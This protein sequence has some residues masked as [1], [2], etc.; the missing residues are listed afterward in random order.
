MEIMETEAEILVVD[1]EPAVALAITTA[2][3]F[4][5]YAVV[6][7]SSGEE[8]LEHVRA[9]PGRFPI[10]LSDH[11]MP[12][13]GG[14][15]LVRALHEIG[16]GGRILILSAFLSC[17]LETQYKALGVDQILAK[18]FDLRGLRLALDRLLHPAECAS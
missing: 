2:L 18:P 4:C 6:A 9:E 13:L 7:V 14:V 5:G 16:Y 1:D 8:A 12:G 11:N 17:D 3:K 10:I 15:A